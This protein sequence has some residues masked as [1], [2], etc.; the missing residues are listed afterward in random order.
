MEC[1]YTRSIVYIAIERNVKIEKQ[2]N[3][4]LWKIVQWI[5]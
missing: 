2:D 5:N 4:I 3:D 1:V